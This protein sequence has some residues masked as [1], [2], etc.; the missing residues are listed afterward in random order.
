[1]KIAQPALYRHTDTIK[2]IRNADGLSRFI[3]EHGVR[4][5]G[6][7]AA[8]ASLRSTAREPF[9]PPILRDGRN[10]AAE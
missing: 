10:L 3:A 7:L 2:P 6:S 4:L 8:A 9:I 5:T 1:M